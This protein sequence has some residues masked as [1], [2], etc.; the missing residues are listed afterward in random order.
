M[1]KILVTLF[2]ALVTASGAMAQTSL[3]QSIL[4]AVDSVNIMESQEAVLQLMAEYV[5]NHPSVTL[6]IGGF[7]SS[8]T[9]KE[10]VEDLCTK[11]AEAVKERL[12]K[13]YNVPS[14]RLVAIGAGV[15]TR[16]DEPEFNEVVT[17][18]Q[19]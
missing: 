13:V 5:R 15:S 11:R 8:R 10:K 16:Y 18:F 1:K 3:G 17:F 9:P 19:K 2:L 6:I 14:T 4:F 7:T 12:V